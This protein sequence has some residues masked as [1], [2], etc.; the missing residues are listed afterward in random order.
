MG[1]ALGK[2]LG[3]ALNEGNGCFV[4][5]TAGLV[6]GRSIAKGFNSGTEAFPC[7]SSGPVD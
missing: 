3:L 7:S 2:C 1:A 4:F 6:Q 5:F